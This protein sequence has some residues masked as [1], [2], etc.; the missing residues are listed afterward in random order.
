MK[1]DTLGLLRPLPFF[2][3]QLKRRVLHCFSPRAFSAWGFGVG[4]FLLSFCGSGCSCVVVFLLRH[5]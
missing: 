1:R 3:E 5:T 4:F 2:N